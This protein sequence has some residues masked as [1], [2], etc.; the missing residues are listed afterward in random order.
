MKNTRTYVAIV[1]VSAISAALGAYLL[2]PSVSDREIAA[3]AVLAAL[4]MF[5]EMLTFALPRSASGSIAFIPY[6]A[7]VMVVPSW[8]TIIAATLVKLLAEIA[9]RRELLKRAFNIAQLTV[10]LTAAVATYRAFGGEGM[11]LD[12]I[13][14]LSETTEA[15]GL[16]A[17]AAFV[18]AFTVNSV[19]V[20]RAV[21]LANDIPFLQA[22]RENVIFAIALDL[23]ASPIVFLFAWL[24]AEYGA[25]AAF[26]VWA[27]IVGLKQL[28]TTRVELEQTNQ[29]LLEL[30]VKSIEARDSY[31]SGHSRRVR[32]YALAIA[33]ATGLSER[34]VAKVGKAALLHDV[35]KIHE[36]YAPILAKPDRLTPDEWHLMKQHPIDG[37]ELVGTMT[38]L[39]ELIPAVRHHHERWDGRG[40]PDAIAG[41]DI[42]LA[43][44][45][46]ALADTIDAMTS[47]RPYR[48]ALT[49]ADVRAELIRCRA[50]QFDPGLVDRLLESGALEKLFPPVRGETRYKS[51]SVVATTA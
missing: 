5:A 13:S 22:I 16:A 12:G 7:A 14:R 19:L 44:R 41:E 49:G 6:L 8:P 42:P 48:P 33:R 34:E 24:Y 10:T 46:I 45:I 37:A 4:A 1:C 2:Q 27:P 17:L 30:M 26:A 20:Q 38:R 32:D 18:V 36:K 28:T 51:L 21:A 47:E 50:R 29:E 35:G 25:I 39:R 11:L 3:V 9:Q 43:A 31:T 40:Y 15:S 23:L